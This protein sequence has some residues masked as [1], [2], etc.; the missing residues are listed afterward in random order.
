MGAAVES[1]RLAPAAAHPA[2]FLILNLPFGLTTGYIIAVLP[3]Q[4][5]TS[6]ISVAA[7]A[8]LV[9]FA[10]S[11]KVWKFLWAP[12][13]DLTLSFKRWYV[14]GAAMAAAMLIAC[15][16]VPP[17][18]GL[19]W[20]LAAC[21]FLAEVGTGF[22]T[23]A[24][25]GVMAEAVPDAQKGRTAGW[26]Q[27]GGKLGRGFS[28]GAGIWL[29]THEHSSSTAAIVLGAMCLIPI[30]ALLLVGEPAR[31]GA[32]ASFKAR[33]RQFGRDFSSLFTD[34]RGLF[35]VILVL[36][37]I[38]ISGVSNF[39]SGVASEWSV[40]SNVIALMTGP[41]EA[42]A[43]V[44]G[45]LFA[46][47][48]A[49]QFDRRLV[50]LGCGGLL[51]VVAVLLSEAPRLPLSFIAGT[52]TVSLLLAMGDAAFTALIL[53]VIGIRSAASKYALLGALGNVPDIYMTSISG[54]VHD[55]WG[56]ARML[57]LEAGLSVLCV[58]AAGGWIFLFQRDFSGDRVK[59]VP[60]S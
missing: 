57:Q 53:S 9:A 47:W 51:A 50:Y 40:S 34:R 11:P 14:I 18:R 1:E 10:I 30:S 33:L 31:V 41:M 8:S 27:L 43:S 29:L 26:Y 4:L 49:D 17:S 13:V 2:V 20:L 6:G 42:V 56:T 15:G 46:G 35:V 55:A 38:G 16:F 44:V 48:L 3:L 12:L 45:C 5:T 19:L 7:A 37:P 32:T 21:A 22:L 58:V 54:V 23:T 28:A 59:R 39:W 25:A 60:A 52:F 36:T 24:V